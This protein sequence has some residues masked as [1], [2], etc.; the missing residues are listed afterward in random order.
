MKLYFHPASPFA[1]KPLI[2][3]ALL[4]IELE[5][6]VVDI[7]AGAGQSPEYLKLN[8]QGKVPT[9]VDGDFSLWESNAIVQ[10]LA[11]QAGETALFPRNAQSRADILRWQFWESTSWAPACSLFIYENMVKPILGLGEADPVE[12][13][14]G[15]EKFHRSAK[16]L[17]KHLAKQSWLVG[18]SLSLADISVA[19]VLM[20]AEPAHCP[21]Q[22]YDHIVS[23]FEKIQQLPAWIATS[24]SA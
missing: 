4:G 2:A 15:E 3:A 23:W 5:T 12:L 9:L 14:K 13:K 16:V 8:P 20:Y 24:P 18:D 21:L 6:S 19:P 10:Y 1:R 17:N 22:G 11:E 7:F